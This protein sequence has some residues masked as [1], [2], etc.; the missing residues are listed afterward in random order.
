MQHFDESGDLNNGTIKFLLTNIGKSFINLQEDPSIDIEDDLIPE[1]S[2]GLISYLPFN[3]DRVK[4]IDLIIRPKY[5]NRAT[6]EIPLDENLL[7]YPPTWGT[8]LSINYPKY[9][10]YGYYYNW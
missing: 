9:S 10:E 2:N 8:S 6:Y 4:N 3:E 7:S 1:E 5:A